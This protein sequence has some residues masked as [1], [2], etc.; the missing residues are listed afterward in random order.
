ML[1]AADNEL[2]TRV[3]AGTPMGE[4]MRRYWLP[5]TR[6]EAVPA[7]GEPT[8]VRLLGEDLIV[9]RGTDG[10]LACLDER[11]PHRLASLAL[12]KP[13]GD[14]I[15]CLY[16]GWQFGTDGTCV[17]V[18]TEPAD[19]RADFAARVKV[20]NHPVAEAGG[21]VWIYLGEADTA[22]PL[23]D[24]EFANLP[25]DH[26]TVVVGLTTCNWMQCLEGLVDTVHVGQL[27]QA[28]LPAITSSLASVSVESAPT[29]DIDTADF[30]LRACADRPRGDGSHYVRITEYVAPFWSF[31]PS[32]VKEDR[33]CMAVVPV[34]DT[35][36]LQFYVFH[37]LTQPLDTEDPENSEVYRLLMETPDD[38]ASSVRNKP[39]W[40]QD[41]ASMGGDH[42]T[43]LPNIVLEDVAL[44]ESQGQIMDRTRE[45]LGSSDQFVARTRR[46]LLKAARDLE[47]S[48]TLHPDPA[49]LDV[50][51]VRA[52]AVDIPEGQDW[53]TV[54]S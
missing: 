24:F 54:T 41:R 9:F 36:T 26:V 14:R 30:G 3:G 5:A 22:P 34:D 42:F 18:P 46:F 37:N 20:R 44:Q 38:F 27:H 21:I 16:H 47:A 52:L 15:T 12:A 17:N 31:I 40:G 25:A 2:I 28:W 43:G 33:V 51:S 19:K 7:G 53:R 45:H 6:S 11:C 50:R 39:K 49:T 35:N 48:G 23:P 1:T 10:S 29:Y 4:Y 32:G 8:Q 13:E